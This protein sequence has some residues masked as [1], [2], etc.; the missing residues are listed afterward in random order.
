[1][2]AAVG[3]LSVV[4]VVVA[5]VDLIAQGI[6]SMRDRTRTALAL[7]RPVL[8]IVIGSAVAMAALEAGLLLDDFSIEYIANNSATT[9]PLLFKFAS[10]W[11][12]LEGSILLWGLV[13]AGYVYTVY[14]QMARR[15][16]GDALGA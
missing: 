10:G 11:A 13:L 1:M 16:G 8:G 7:R 3:S 14:R 4:V 2:I 15:A 12:A 9:T 6:R 5:C